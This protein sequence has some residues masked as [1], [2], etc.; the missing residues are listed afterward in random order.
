MKFL[1]TVLLALASAA[2][3]SVSAADAVKLA[4]VYEKIETK[5]PIAVVVPPDGSNREFLALQR[6]QVLM[7]GVTSQVPRHCVL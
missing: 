2:A 1:A 4:R 5:W 6:G 7:T 3:G